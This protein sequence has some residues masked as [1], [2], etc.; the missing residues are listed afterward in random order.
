MLTSVLPLR[1][2]GCWDHYTMLVT[3]Q[4][5]PSQTAEG[6]W[7]LLRFRRGSQTPALV[8]NGCFHTLCHSSQDIFKGVDYIKWTEEE[9]GGLSTH[10]HTHTCST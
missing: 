8:S 2:G 6:C 7:G 10:C 4:G 1:L 3:G 5:G 9:E